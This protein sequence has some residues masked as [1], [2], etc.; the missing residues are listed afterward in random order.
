MLGCESTYV[1]PIG[2]RCSV[3]TCLGVGSP[4]GGLSSLVLSRA[5]NRC[6]S[7]FHALCVAHA[8]LCAMGI[9]G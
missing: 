5:M 7:T 8:Y 2:F 1:V 3:L 4:G 9:G 6:R